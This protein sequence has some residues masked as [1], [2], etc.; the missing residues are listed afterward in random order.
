MGATANGSLSMR[1]WRPPR[2]PSYDLLALDEALGRLAVREP[3]KAVLVKLRFFGG[4]TLP[5]AAQVLGLSVP[6][7]ERYWRFARVW[8]Y[9]DLAGPDADADG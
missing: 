6:T 3:A 2:P 7:A 4:L 1:P 8:L 9:A 5:E